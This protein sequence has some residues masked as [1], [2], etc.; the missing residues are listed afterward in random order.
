MNFC[1]EGGT[2]VRA[3]MAVIMKCSNKRKCF[4]ESEKWKHC[5]E[6]YSEIGQLE[7]DSFMA[8]DRIKRKIKKTILIS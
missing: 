5:Q 1:T 7:L 6:K 3:Y 4:I 8:L 2:S